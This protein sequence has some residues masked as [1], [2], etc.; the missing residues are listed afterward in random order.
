MTRASGEGG[1]VRFRLLSPPLL[2]LSIFGALLAALGAL[3]VS[4]GA[5]IGL[6]IVEIVIGSTLLVRSVR[7]SVEVTD[8]DVIVRNIIRSR[9][10]DRAAVADVG[11][12]TTWLNPGYAIATLEG[13]DLR[14]VKCQGL[15]S[16]KGIHG[17]RAKS[18][19]EQ[20]WDALRAELCQ[21]LSP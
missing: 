5:A 11:R 16:P 1:A 2:T 21:T 20:R 17:R 8:E 4:A 14:R 9:T 18:A 15:C 6:G 3:T 13:R 19:F 12:A 10:I 7:C